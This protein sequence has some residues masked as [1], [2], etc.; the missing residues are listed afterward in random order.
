MNY[1]DPCL[2]NWGGLRTLHLS[3]ALLKLSE[4]DVKPEGRTLGFRV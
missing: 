4:L 1:P 3:L 2:K